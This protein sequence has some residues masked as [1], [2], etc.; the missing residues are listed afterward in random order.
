MP[1]LIKTSYNEA[2]KTCVYYNKKQDS[3]IKHHHWFDKKY[4]SIHPKLMK[5]YYPGILINQTTD[6]YTMKFVYKKIEGVI[7]SYVVKNDK[8]ME[9]LYKAI[10]D[11]LER[12]WP[13][14]H[15]DWAKTNIIYNCQEPLCEE[16]GVPGCPGVFH[17]I[18]WSAMQ[19][20][21]TKEECIAQINKDLEQGYNDI[22]KSWI[23][24]DGAIKLM[25]DYNY[26]L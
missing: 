7:S 14:Y 21:F 4:Y 16:C 17:L 10:L 15:Y 20:G 2:G 9:M 5:K 13:Y 26:E 8:M 12:T 18:D 25:K 19:T 1:K 6:R 22:F 24:T 23:S 11:E 3:F